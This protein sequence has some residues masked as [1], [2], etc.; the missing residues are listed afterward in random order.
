MNIY[1]CRGIIPGM[2]ISLLT[3]TSDI[4][5]LRA[6]ALAMVQ[7][8]VA[9]KNTELMAKEQRIRLLEEAL[10][11]ARLQRF[12][13]KTEML[14]GL[15]R[16]LFE[17][18]TEADIAA[19]ET[20][21]NALLQQDIKEEKP[22]SPH[23][24]RKALPS[25][26]PRVKK[27]IPPASDT[28]ADCNVALRFIRDEISEK[29]EY[30]PAHFVV[31]QYVRPQYGCPCCEKVFSGQMPAQLIPKGIAE[32]SLVAQVVVGKY[33]DY[34]PL[35]RQQHI[36]ARAEVGL[37][38]STMAGWVGTAGV[39]LNPLATLLHR[40]LLT[41]SVLHADE[42]TLRILDT[43]KGGKARS[44]YLWA[45]VSGEK[46]GPAIVC[47]DSQTGRA[48]EH[49]ATWLK[50][51][52]GSLVV[53]GYKAYETLAENVPGIRLVGCW[54]HARRGFADLYKANQDPRAAMAVRQIAGLYRLEKK[55]RHRP[56][57]K[58]R[59][60]RQR[61]S[62]PVIDKLWSWLEQQ[63]D[64]CPENSAL[65]K[66]V[67]YMLKRRETLSRFLDDGTLPLDNNRCERAI[68]PVVMG[69]SNWLFAGSLAAGTRAAQIMSLLETAKMNGLEPH[70]WLTDV[71]T[72]LPS[73]PEERLHELLPYPAYRF[74]APE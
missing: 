54:A 45:Y 10:M 33:R 53:D 11:L 61:Y 28:C 14:S 4:E 6:M 24:V 42:T 67:G 18:D 30:I 3:T 2:D 27:T 1:L 23:P 74:A 60:W 34:Q 13:R 71:L 15:Q 48:H 51:W 66:A 8:V 25:Q 52:R 72:R 62:R 7:N 64:A 70:T 57:E 68:R 58:I 46:S 40:E 26:L 38:V 43:R 63:K 32:A 73:W 39:A 20:Q 21:L 44:G 37:P 12:G 59:Q 35:Y 19:A 50:G 29:L 69:R 65:G 55:I 16:Q 17:E 22:S 49:P 47:F 41:R 31:N 56:A 9:E 36:F 5:Q